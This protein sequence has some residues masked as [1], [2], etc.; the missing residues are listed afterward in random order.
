MTAPQYS[1]HPNN[2]VK[3]LNAKSLQHYRRI[4]KNPMRAASFAME[5]LVAVA[6]S[7]E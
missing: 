6:E 4:C 1:C 5:P 7:T 2:S 3:A